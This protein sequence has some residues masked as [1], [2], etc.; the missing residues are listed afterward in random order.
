MNGKLLSLL[1]NVFV[2]LPFLAQG[3]SKD[4]TWV[5]GNRVIEFHKTTKEPVASNG[6]VALT[7][8]G[9]VAENP[10]N[11]DILFY[12]DGVNVFDA[13]NQVMVNGTGLN[14]DVS[15][16]Q[17]VVVGQVPGSPN[18]FYILTHNAA[19]AIEV[20]T[21]DM[22]L[23]GNAAAVPLGEVTTK[24]VPIPALVNQSDGMIT[25][26]HANGTDFWLIT[27]TTGTTTYNITLVNSSGFT[28]TSFSLV[29]LIQDVANFSYN[30]T[31]NQLAVSPAEANRNVEILNFDPASGSLS[32]EAGLPLSSTTA[33]QGIFDVE[34]SPLGDYVYISGY[35]STGQP[36]LLQYDLLNISIPP[37][38]GLTS[39]QSVLPQPNTVT[40]SFGL[41][42]GPDTVLYHL[43]EQ[44]G[45]IRMGMITSPDS[46]VTVGVGYDPVAF[47]GNFSVQQFPS[48][49]PNPFPTTIDFTFDNPCMNVPTQFFP[50][51]S[52]PVD[53]LQWTLDGQPMSSQWSPNHTFDQGGTFT[54]A[55]TAFVGGVA[56]ATNQ[57]AVTVPQTNI[58]V[59]LDPEITGCH[60]EFKFPIIQPPAGVPKCGEP[61]GSCL[62]VTAEIQGGGTIQWFG[63]DGPVASGTT[64]TIQPERPGYYWITVA[65]PGGCTYSAGILVKEYDTQDPR[66]FVWYFGDQAGLDFNPLVQ[67]P[68]P[69]PMV[70]VSAENAMAAPQGT[71]T[72]SDRN[73]NVI[74]YTDGQ[75]VWVQGNPTPITTNL[76]GS[77]TSTQGT[78]IMPVQGDET[79]FYIFTTEEI[80]TGGYEL[81]YAVFDRKLDPVNGLGDLVDP[82]P[83]DPL[84]EPS[85]VLFTKSTERILGINNWIV[86]HEFGN[87]TFRAYQVT[88][89]GISEPVYSNVGA[90]HSVIS[91]TSGEGYMA[92]AAGRIAVVYTDATGSWLQ[93]FDFDSATGEVTNARPPVAIPGAGTQAYGVAI[94]PGGER[95]FVTTLGDNSIHE[96]QYNTVTDVYAYLNPIAGPTAQ[97]G[98]IVPGLGGLYVS[99]E[100]ASALGLINVNTT[101]GTSSTFN[102][103]GTIPFAGQ[104]TLGLPNFVQTTATPVMEPAL[105]I[106]NACEG[107]DVTFIANGKD[108]L[109]DQ[110][111]WFF[112]DGTTMIDAGP[113]VVKNYPVAGNNYSV[114]VVIY[115]KCMPKIPQGSPGFPGG[116]EAVFTRNFEVFAIP[117]APLMLDGAAPIICG[118]TPVT[119]K[120]YDNNDPDFPAQLTYLWSEGSTTDELVTANPGTYSV[121]VTSTRTTC[122]NT[123]QVTL[124]PYFST[125]DLGPDI[126]LCQGES[127][128]F[129]AGFDTRAQYTWSING[130]AQPAQTN[131]NEFTFTGGALTSPPR[132]TFTL[133]VVMQDPRCTQTDQVLITVNELPQFNVT[134]LPDTDC[135]PAVN[136][137]QITLDITGPASYVFSYTVSNSTAL[138]GSGVDID[139]ADVIGPFTGLGGDAYSIIVSDQLSGCARPHVETINNADLA[140]T[141][142][143]NGQCHPAMGI[144]VQVSTGSPDFS[145]TLLDQTA[146]PISAGT[147]SAMTFTTGALGSIQD[148]NYVMRLRDNLGCVT[149][150][151]ITLTSGPSYQVS[152]DATN[153]CNDINQVSTA[154]TPADATAVP[155]WTA[156]NP[157]GANG[158][159]Q[160]NP[161]SGNTASLIQGTW[162]VSV[163]ITGNAA[164]PGTATRTLAV[165]D[166]VAVTIDDPPSNCVNPITLNASLSNAS[167]S[168]TYDWTSEGNPFA[169]GNPILVPS[170]Q[171]GNEF[172]VTFTNSANGCAYTSGPKT[173]T[174]ITPFT[175]AVTPPGVVCEET[176]FQIT[177]TPSRPD[178]TQFIWTFNGIQIPENGPILTDDRGGTYTVAGTISGCQSPEVIIP[179]TPIPTPQVEIGPLRRICPHPAAPDEQEFATLDPQAAFPGYEWFFVGSDGVEQPLNNTSQTHDAVLPGT[180]R[181]TVTD[182]SGCPGTDE[183]EVIEEC[184][185]IISGPNAFRPTSAIGGNKGFHLFT[186]FI[187]DEDFQILIFN[188]WGEM[189]YEST[190][191]EFTWNGGYKGSKGQILPAGTYAYVVRYRSR[192]FPDEGIQ[193]KRGGVVLLQ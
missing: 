182:A 51:V 88:T 142:T 38:T 43:Y 106:T 172:V 181:L 138:I 165:F 178:V 66:A 125:L 169:S 102:P 34:W 170:A 123:A 73:G 20:T 63:P 81:R 90:D 92:F 72:I 110:F 192:Y 148:G 93:V 108:P 115:N 137:G 17:P 145:W 8:T 5:L 39:P 177:A 179:I 159:D 114:T 30:P 37:P 157:A 52:Q 187:E 171:S 67:V 163:T 54:V 65:E 48:A 147:N 120:G 78:L 97:P 91:T 153:I 68:T 13:T 56:V 127:Q 140:F 98:A 128:L 4:F 96:F 121:T 27:H 6:P 183:V 99:V 133:E 71:A 49:L 60:E 103:Q 122:T 118:N 10:A 117:L 15:A 136:T 144:D 155:A 23:T 119:L 77:P 26:P 70:D 105:T 79:L 158:L 80:S 135:S 86:V 184:D 94:S 149:S 41:Q 156:T 25:I 151:P 134:S 74:F 44:G 24:N 16:N 126:D 174:I 173:V 175:V 57:K 55:V 143:Q 112:S 62:D 75:S 95:I 2:V 46:V 87:N 83:T 111:D 40:E 84:D 3:Q 132:E 1:L 76:G 11:G 82:T 69:G 32:F 101:P 124:N 85:T 21:V 109:I 7:G 59:T 18:L 35:N 191:R 47:T 9:A 164:C 180:Y 89:D 162:N 150:E 14:A 154:F 100:G 61:G 185:P 45:V 130:V 131:P 160:N 33:P 189:V 58:Q 161:P 190:S 31:T 36:D 28:T 193:E 146:Q 152:I 107:G 116:G 139:A 129:Q 42:M 113:E 188:R 104:A 12:T 19:G 176:D 53:S 22:A 168:G 141:P 64:A 50:S 167:A 29:G 186:F 166:P